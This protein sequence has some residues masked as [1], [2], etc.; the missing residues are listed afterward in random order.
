MSRCW[1]LVPGLRNTRVP[2]VSRGVQAG[3][4]LL[5]FLPSS[6]HPT[7]SIWQ[8][9]G[10]TYPSPLSVMERRRGAVVGVLKAGAKLEALLRT[11][12]WDEGDSVLRLRIGQFL[13]PLPSPAPSHTLFSSVGSSR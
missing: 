10:D 5:R 4:F 13:D 11:A 8:E 3:S 12:D 7:P 6:P 9:I 1:S 2:E